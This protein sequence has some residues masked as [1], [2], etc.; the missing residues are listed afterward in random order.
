MA[1]LDS[2]G[3][4]FSTGFVL[5]WVIVRK[6]HYI[7]EKIMLRIVVVV[8]VGVGVGVAVVVVVVVVDDRIKM[9][10]IFR[11]ISHLLMLWVQTQI[12]LQNPPELLCQPRVSESECQFSSSSNHPN[13]QM[14]K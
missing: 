14:Q 6:P 12:L 1:H 13:Y 9:R 11:L 2:Q 7:V 3:G 8:V 10:Q 5:L 4:C